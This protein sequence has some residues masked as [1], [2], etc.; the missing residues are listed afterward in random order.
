MWLV[1]CILKSLRGTN[2]RSCRPA[3]IFD[4]PRKG[5]APDITLKGNPISAEK[6]ERVKDEKRGEE[7]RGGKRWRGRRRVVKEG[8]E[9][10]RRDGGKN[11]RASERREEKEGGGGRGGESRGE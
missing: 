7:G 2:I 9:E 8:R 6:E 1:T 4:S 11:W 5:A 3:P 10:E